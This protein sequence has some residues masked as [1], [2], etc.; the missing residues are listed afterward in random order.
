MSRKAPFDKQI[1]RGLLAVIGRAGYSLVEAA[2][3]EEPEEDS[4]DL[5][6]RRLL[7]LVEQATQ[8]ELPSAEPPPAEPLSAE[9]LPAEPPPAEPPPTPPHAEPPP[10]VAP[11]AREP[12]ELPAVPEPN[13]WSLALAGAEEPARQLSSWLEL[14]LASADSPEV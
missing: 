12:G 10:V 2:E 4:D 14:R 8:A 7:A 13:P 11:W 9:S 5:A 6:V 3:G 1:A